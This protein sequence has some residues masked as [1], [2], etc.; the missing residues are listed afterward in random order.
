MAKRAK[1][2]A[3]LDG[4]EALLADAKFR[5]AKDKLYA[6]MGDNPDNAAARKRLQEEF[7]PVEKAYFAGRAK[8]H[9]QRMV[10]AVDDGY[11]PMGV[12]LTD[13][14]DPTEG[15]VV[16]LTKEEAQ[17]LGEQLQKILAKR[18]S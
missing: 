7:A 11:L 17:S 13:P 16:T 5:A 8:R 1:S 10:E 3:S 2:S 18:K 6:G 14:K 12:R 15:V 4:D 9:N